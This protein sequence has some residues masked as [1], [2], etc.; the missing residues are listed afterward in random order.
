[1]NKSL[2]KHQKNQSVES[3]DQHHGTPVQSV[4]QHSVEAENSLL[5]ILTKNHSE[6]IEDEEDIVNRQSI[7]RQD[8]EDEEDTERGVNE[9][10]EKDGQHR[11]KTT[12]ES[13]L[14]SFLQKDQLLETIG[15]EYYLY[16]DH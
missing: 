2:F 7:D 12:N 1:M 6:S 10:E 3:V 13:D 14:D 5:T 16:D 11:V 8:D 9:D 4:S 15:E